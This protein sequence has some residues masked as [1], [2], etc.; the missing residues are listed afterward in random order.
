MNR[1]LAEEKQRN[2]QQ[3][4]QTL[5]GSSV[6]TSDVLTADV[7]KDLAL[8]HVTHFSHLQPFVFCKYLEHLFTYLSEKM[9]SVAEC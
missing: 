8:V 3:Q 7:R 4:H 1:Q 6:S 2:E 5:S 9:N